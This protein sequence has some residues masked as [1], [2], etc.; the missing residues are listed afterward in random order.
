[1]AEQYKWNVNAMQELNLHRRC[2][3]SVHLHFTSQSQCCRCRNIPHIRRHI[4]EH[5]PFEHRPL[6]IRA[7]FN[8]NLLCNFLPSHGAFKYAADNGRIVGV[9]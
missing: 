9:V 2:G 5:V 1:M 3:R 6:W 8:S 7:D 4:L